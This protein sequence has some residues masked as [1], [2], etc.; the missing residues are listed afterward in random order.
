MK[1]NLIVEINEI[2]IREMSKIEEK[3]VLAFL[4]GRENLSSKWEHEDDVYTF[5]IG[6]NEL[7]PLLEFLNWSELPVTVIT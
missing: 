6:A 5:V 3:G 2:T 4:E 7:R 1:A